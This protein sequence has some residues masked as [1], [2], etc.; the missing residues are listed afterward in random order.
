MQNLK[1]LCFQFRLLFLDD[2]SIQNQTAAF[3][4][5]PSWRDVTTSALAGSGSLAAQDTKTKKNRHKEFFSVWHSGKNLLKTRRL[6]KIKVF[7]ADDVT[8]S[9]SMQYGLKILLIIQQL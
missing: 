8:I 3:L 2:L 6:E 1:T 4:F 9:N 5:Q 7:A